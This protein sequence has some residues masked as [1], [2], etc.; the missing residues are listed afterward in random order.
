MYVDDLF[1]W[2]G[3]IKYVKSKLSKSTAIIYRCNHLLD[4]NSMYILYCSL[5]LFYLTYCVEI[6]GNTS[7][8][9]G[10]F[11]LQ[12]KSYPHCVWG[13]AF[14]SYELT[15]STIACLKI[16]IYYRTENAIIYVQSLLFAIKRSAFIC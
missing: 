8:I 2:N 9:N 11:L 13:E 3:H 4:Q 12:K 15:F 7:N 14:G 10:I 6:W 5:I 1:N 16:A